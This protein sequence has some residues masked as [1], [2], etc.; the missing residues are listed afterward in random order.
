MFNLDLGNVWDTSKDVTS[1]GHGGLILGLRPA[2]ERRGYK[3]SHWLG[4]NLK[5]AVVMVVGAAN[6][7][8]LNN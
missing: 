1:C 4:T 8:F 3:V 7:T 2:N 5:S 6:R